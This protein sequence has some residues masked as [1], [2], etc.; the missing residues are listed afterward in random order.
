MYLKS[1]SILVTGAATLPLYW[2]C[3]L[4][5]ESIVGFHLARVCSLLWSSLLASRLLLLSEPSAPEL[6][7]SSFLFGNFD[8]GAL[9]LNA[10]VIYNGI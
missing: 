5:Q 1:S 7:S 9:L 4:L 2:F 8:L 6:A 10:S 3:G